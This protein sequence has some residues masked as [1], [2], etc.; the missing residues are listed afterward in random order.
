VSR[1]PLSKPTI[2]I[3]FDDTIVLNAYNL[4]AAYNPEY[5]T[6]LKLESIYAPG[7]LGNAA[8]GWKH[9]VEALS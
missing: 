1:R 3:D 7:E 5:D 4:V 8:S 2:A 9:D 6:N